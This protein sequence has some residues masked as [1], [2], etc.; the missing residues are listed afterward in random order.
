[1]RV[2][3][4]GAKLGGFYVPKDHHLR[5]NVADQS[6]GGWFQTNNGCP[7]TACW[8]PGVSLWFT[9]ADAYTYAGRDPLLL[10]EPNV[11]AFSNRFDDGTIWF[12]LSAVDGINA[13][14]QLRYGKIDR[15]V[16][17]PLFE[18]QRH[19]ETEENTTQE[20]LQ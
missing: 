5:I 8:G 15:M 1:M 7:N 14:L 11:N 12:D 2:S 9:R 3:G 19:T 18:S 10:V 4:K 13:N 17:V 16:S 20:F 6:N